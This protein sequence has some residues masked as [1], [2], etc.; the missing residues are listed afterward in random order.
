LRGFVTNFPEADV[1]TRLQFLSIDA[2][3]PRALAGFWARM[4]HWDVVDD[5]EATGFSW[6]RADDLSLEFELTTEPK[7]A[8]NRIH[9]DLAS[10]TLAEQTAKVER[11][12]YLG[13]THLDI[14][15]GDVP[16]VVLAD[17]EGNEF[18]VLEPREA[19]RDTGPVA[20][21]VMD[22]EDREAMAAFWTV[23]TG[24]PVQHANDHLVA[25]RS[26]DGGGSYLELLTVGEPKAVK[27]RVRLNIGP[28]P[29]DD[30]RAEAARLAALG[31][32]LADIGP[33][34]ASWIVMT[35]PEGQEFCVLTPR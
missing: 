12:L 30:Q 16:W 20:A 27:N 18:C 22:C 4:L 25:L 8:K 24:W 9:L 17:P 31:A 28:C 5:D 11:A 34:D 2:A 7:A 3:D 35:D 1:A 32:R 15:Q 19:Y 13:A 21:I 14:G 33:G 26:P 23:A 6:P 29:Q 10:A